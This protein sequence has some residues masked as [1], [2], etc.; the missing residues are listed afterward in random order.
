MITVGNR[1]QQLAFYP[2]QK[3]GILVEPALIGNKA[4]R[5]IALVTIEQPIHKEFIGD[6]GT[7][8]TLPEYEESVRQLRLVDHPLLL[9]MRR[10]Q[11]HHIVVQFQFA[12]LQ[13]QITAA[14]TEKEKFEKIGLKPFVLGQYSAYLPAVARID[15]EIGTTLGLAKRDMDQPLWI[16]HPLDAFHV[17]LRLFRKDTHDEMKRA[18]VSRYFHKDR[19][20]SCPIG[21]PNGSFIKM[22]YLYRFGA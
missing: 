13:K 9:L 15:I 2:G 17:H 1:V 8:E 20:P 5:R 22:A 6:E 19:L 7:H 4:G 3:L 12:S 16:H 10:Q 14:L 21:S 11:Q 18:R